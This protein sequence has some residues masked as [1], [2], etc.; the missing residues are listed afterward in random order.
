M[1]EVMLRS[2]K[3]WVG[4]EELADPSDLR[5]CGLQCSTGEARELCMKADICL[6]HLRRHCVLTDTERRDA[7]VH[8]LNIAQSM[9]SPQDM[10]EGL[11]TDHVPTE[12]ATLLLGALADLHTTMQAISVGCGVQDLSVPLGGERWKQDKSNKVKQRKR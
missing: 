5:D 3:A 10:F 1:E 8:L 11:M 4:T 2:I 9:P 7:R 6:R 12:E